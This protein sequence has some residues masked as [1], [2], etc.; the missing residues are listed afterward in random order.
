M[1]RLRLSV[2]TAGSRSLSRP[3]R[4]MRKVVVPSGSPIMNGTPAAICVPAAMNLPTTPLSSV[5]TT[6]TPG[7]WKPGA[8]TLTSPLASHM[9][10][11]TR[12]PSSKAA[13]LA[14]SK[15]KSLVSSITSRNCARASVGMVAWYMKP[16]A[17]YASISSSHFLRSTTKEVPWEA[18]VASTPRGPNMTR[19]AHE[20]PVQPFCGAEMSTSTPSSFMSTH[21]VPDAMQSSTKRPPCAWTAAHARR[22][23]SSCSKM[24]VLVST[25][26][27]KS[28]AGLSRAIMA[29][30][31]SIGHGAYCACRPGLATGW[32]LTTMCSDGMS[33][34]SKMCVHR[35]EK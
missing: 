23:Y 1:A 28:T 14:L 24:P 15:P 4:P 16:P 11:R 20:G 33:H 27:A 21:T 19:P 12:S 31:S 22:M 32:A 9:Y 6:T 18:R 13:A 29:S 35:Y 2:V 25:W 26:G 3:K 34:V 7:D 5:C 17:S 10:L 30:R 8:A